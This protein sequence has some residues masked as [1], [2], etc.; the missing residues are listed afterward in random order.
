MTIKPSKLMAL[1][2]SLY[3]RRDP[4]EDAVLN[5][6]DWDPLKFPLMRLMGPNWSFAARLD[7]LDEALYDLSTLTESEPPRN[8]H[9]KKIYHAPTGL[10]A[11]IGGVLGGNQTPYNG[12]N[13]RF[14][15]VAINATHPD[16]PNDPWQP[17]GPGIG[18]EPILPDRT[19]SVILAPFGQTPFN[20]WKDYHFQPAAR[21]ISGEIWSRPAEGFVEKAREVL[22]LGPPVD[23]DPD[24]D[25]MVFLADGF[26]LRGTIVLP[27]DTTGTPRTAWFKAHA[28]R[29]NAAEGPRLSIWQGAPLDPDWA[30]QLN[31]LEQILLAASGAD[32]APQWLEL[33]AASAIRPQDLR[34]PC[35]VDSQILLHRTPDDPVQIASDN[36]VVQ[37][38]TDTDGR[39]GRISIRPDGFV[40]AKDV[41]NGVPRLIIANQSAPASLAASL[42]ALDPRSGHDPGR[43]DAWYQ[44]SRTEKVIDGQPTTTIQEDLGLGRVD[45]NARRLQ[46]AIPTLSNAARMR[47]AMGFPEPRVGDDVDRLW[48]FTPL[49]NGWL[50]WPIPNATQATVEQEIKTNTPSATQANMHEEHD[51]TAPSFAT[52]GLWSM[53]PEEE[54]QERDWS[55][56]LANALEAD[57]SIVLGR[58]NDTWRVD[59]AQV[60]LRDL[61]V[62]FDGVVPVTAFAQ[63]SERLLPEA[64]ERALR[65]S[66]LSAV[67]PSVLTGAERD[68][69]DAGALKIDATVESLQLLPKARAED[70][71]TGATFHDTVH[72]DK[73]QP[74]QITVTWPDPSASDVGPHDPWLWLRHDSLPT[75]QTMPLATAGEAARQP[76]S[77][78]ELTPLITRHAD[79]AVVQFT[80]AFRMDQPGPRIDD[81]ADL[82]GKHPLA[83]QPYRLD[84]GNAVTTLPSLT[85]TAG[86]RDG[87]AGKA[88]AGVPTSI[89]TRYHHH[90]ALTDEFFALAK[91]PPPPAKDDA[92]DTTRAEDPVPPPLTFEP[93]PYNA[94]GD[95]EASAWTNVWAGH[96]RALGLATPALTKMSTG[97]GLSDVIFGTTWDGTVQFSDKTRLVG[98]DP[99]SAVYGDGLGLARIAEIGTVT[100]DIDGFGKGTRPGLPAT[101]DLMGLTA[102]TETLAITRG[103]LDG[104]GSTFSYD[105]AGYTIGPAKAQTNLIVRAVQRSKVRPDDVVQMS[106]QFDQQISMIVPQA[107]ATNGT[108]DNAPQFHFRDVAVTQRKADLREAWTDDPETFG[109]DKAGDGALPDHNLD[110]GFSWSL[111]QPGLDGTVTLGPFLFEPVALTEI[112]TNGATD[113]TQAEL[114]G[115]VGLP[116]D[117]R[118]NSFLA[119]AGRATLVLTNKTPAGRLD[120]QLHIV[121]MS[122]PLLDDDDIPSGPP[123][124]QARRM[125]LAWTNGALSLPTL[126]G[127]A[128]GFRLGGKFEE[129]APSTVE[130]NL[131]G[132]DLLVELPEAELTDGRLDLRDP[133]TDKDNPHVLVS[134]PVLQAAAPPPLRA[135][136]RFQLDLVSRSTALLLD[137]TLDLLR[138]KTLSQRDSCVLNHDQAQTV[139]FDIDADIQL[140][141]ASIGVE[142][143][144]A[145]S[146]AELLGTVLEDGRGAALASVRAEAGALV[147]GQVKHVFQLH[148]GEHLTLNFDDA[149]EGDPVRLRGRIEGRN[150]FSWPKLAFA[151]DAAATEL[152]ASHYQATP[153]TG[154]MMHDAVVHLDQTRVSIPGL[155]AGQLRMV[156]RVDHTLLHTVDG[157][158]DKA[159]HGWSVLQDLTIWSPERL[160]KDLETRAQTNKTL[161]LDVP[162]GENDFRPN[163]VWAADAGSSGLTREQMLAFAHALAA[164]GEGAPVVDLSS[165][166]LLEGGL[167]D[168]QMRPLPLPGFLADPSLGNLFDFDGT[169]KLIRRP[170][171][172]AL[173]R[174]LPPLDARS[175][176]RLKTRTD[177]AAR[178]A[179]RLRE[180]LGS[181][182]GQDAT[183]RPHRPLFQSAA[184]VVDTDGPLVQDRLWAEIAIWLSAL[185]QRASRR[186]PRRAFTMVGRGWVSDTLVKEPLAKEALAN[187]SPRYTAAAHALSWS[188]EVLGEQSDLILPEPLGAGGRP[189]GQFLRLLALGWDG[190]QITQ[191]ASAA[192]AADLPE[193]GLPANLLAWAQ[194]TLARVAPWAETGLVLLSAGQGDPW[195]LSDRTAI[196]ASAATDRKRPARVSKLGNDAGPPQL[197]RNRYG[198]NPELATTLKDLHGYDPVGMAAATLTSRPGELPPAGQTTVPLT[199]SG[200]SF[201]ATLG[202]AGRQVQNGHTLWMASRKV[203]PFRGFQE[204]PK[205]SPGTLPGVT[206]TLPPGHRGAVPAALLPARAGDTRPPSAELGDLSVLPSYV[207]ETVVAPRSGVPMAHRLGIQAA[208]ETDGADWSASEAPQ[209]I[210]TPRPVELG[211]NDRPVASAFEPKSMQLKTAPEAMLFGG[212]AS[213]SHLD[214]VRAGLDRAPRAAFAHRLEVTTPANGLLPE[215]WDGILEVQI[216]ET[217]G[218]PPEHQAW[219][220]DEAV[221]EAGDHV[222]TTTPTA[223]ALTPGEPF[224]LQ[225]FLPVGDPDAQPL[226]AIRAIR[227]LPSG[228]PGR[229]TLRV[230]NKGLTRQVAFSLWRAGGRLIETPAYVRFE[231]PGYNDILTGQPKLARIEIGESDELLILAET[232]EVRPGDF[233]EA[234]L[235][236]LSKD[237]GATPKSK[238]VPALGT[239][240]PAAIE[241]DGVQSPLT[242]S[243]SVERPGQPAAIEVA[244]PGAG[245]ADY[246]DEVFAGRPLQLARLTDGTGQ[247]AFTLLENDRLRITAKVGAGG[248]TLSLRLDVVNRPNLPPNPAIYHMLSFGEVT[249]PEAKLPPVVHAPLQVTSPKPFLVQLVDPAEMAFGIVRRRALF[250]WSTFLNPGSGRVWRYALQ[251]DVSTGAAWLGDDLRRHWQVPDGDPAQPLNQ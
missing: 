2:P 101:A 206:P 25:L 191:V 106:D 222:L 176:Q 27:W 58:P 148:I 118:P 146:G 225:G 68:L 162:S 241:V 22:G 93:L 79:G 43:T 10:T 80:D 163:I 82:T 67:S 224:I 32:L 230:Q 23:D 7:A 187:K 76:S 122:V 14:S 12:P 202:Q 3:S 229:L 216:A 212:A 96:T 169:G 5:T 211:V 231:D 244:I 90:I 128:I 119:S 116:G 120:W 238:F 140:A 210:R 177:R 193:T 40:I 168:G 29:G 199:A 240:G 66:W 232:A 94:P 170:M 99:E 30:E 180:G 156:A 205:S 97:Q 9:G 204:V 88:W 242:L 135:E 81:T 207:Q 48:L 21:L 41:E 110:H 89:G 185:H 189:A 196:V 33:R 77:L 73:V 141:A 198:T 175:L 31:A 153:Q 250:Q 208:A 42:A 243:L 194:A 154:R 18:D 249:D 214:P 111:V 234:G 17:F 53:M 47:D 70:A 197:H 16:F 64:N 39:S 69:W 117:D 209:W 6:R 228:S 138:K 218:T 74:L 62:S 159:W 227:D 233:V 11:R 145:R 83:D 85:L 109:H 46:L 132:H 65:G 245:Q 45:G 91:L 107:L 24:R 123:R 8:L 213:L 251:K 236:I 54:D 167:A 13:S 36:L 179:E 200:A 183:D 113:W 28:F 201:S 190:A 166:H 139:A 78:R 59:R 126:E 174:G 72:N 144:Q 246:R 151:E 105:Q 171:E 20:Q 86:L 188:D 223:N 56:S 115:R 44:F 108:A 103:A 133:T 186:S 203:V 142:W 37:L 4:V 75:F 239:S 104:Y 192:V 87:A 100:T 55:L 155:V 125:T 130:A 150:L 221:I 248:P 35:Q 38:G 173:E 220:V 178:T 152:D 92:N 181:V 63:T 160:A 157:A 165:H 219:T 1:F 143:R 121:D 61:T 161:S 137:Q 95:I 34:W 129:P 26:A 158:Q 19:T 127:V 149:L 136:Y 49:P 237:P 147:P 102:S 112:I 226:V 215:D 50:H 51:P 134:L 98:D 172:W 60:S 247:T 182:L 184:T 217:F 57:F 15:A 84:I 114:V 235:A 71:Q 164:D 131:G 52:S 124:L 195:H